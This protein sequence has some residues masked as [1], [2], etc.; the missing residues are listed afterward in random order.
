MRHKIIYQLICRPK[1]DSKGSNQW[2]R[3]HHP[4]SSSFLKTPSILSM[5]HQDLS[6]H[7]QYHGQNAAVHAKCSNSHYH[8]VQFSYG[9]YELPWTS[10]LAHRKIYQSMLTRLNRNLYQLSKLFSSALSYFWQIWLKQWLVC[11]LN[12]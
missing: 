6:E 2:H 1:Q 8:P 12:W 10:Y 4:S 3:R 7:Y 9:T 5:F 11:A